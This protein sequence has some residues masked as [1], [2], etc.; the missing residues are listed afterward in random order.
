MD[1]I[2]FESD[3]FDDVVARDPRY[4]ARAYAVLMDVV[5]YLGESGGHISSA[6]ILE[7]FKE[8][9][10]DQFGPLS[11]TVLSEWG[12]TCTEDVGEMMFNLVEARRVRK[13]DCDT[14]DDFAAGYDFKETFLG[15]YGA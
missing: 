11:Y 13:D 3:T 9:V 6:D 14:A 1:D 10:L 5:H 2:D 7:E 15:P 12:V 8:T 4:D